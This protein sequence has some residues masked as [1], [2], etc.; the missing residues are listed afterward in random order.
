MKFFSGAAARKIEATTIALVKAHLEAGFA[1]PLHAPEF[2]SG[3]GVRVL[4]SDLLMMRAVD[5][6][7]ARPTIFLSFE[8]GKKMPFSIPVEGVLRSGFKT[9]VNVTAEVITNDSCAE[10]ETPTR[11]ALENIVE[12]GRKTLRLAGFHQAA[13]DPD[14]RRSNDQNKIFPISIPGVIYTLQS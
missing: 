11:D 13:T 6:F 2:A 5:D 14:P 3:G 10:L 9:E 1:S 4:D 12:A 7:S 8:R